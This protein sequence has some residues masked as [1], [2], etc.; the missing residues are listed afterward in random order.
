MKYVLMIMVLAT[1]MV[2][3]LTAVDQSTAASAQD[4]KAVKQAAM[5]L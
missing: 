5:V 2:F 1:H 4:E 3:P